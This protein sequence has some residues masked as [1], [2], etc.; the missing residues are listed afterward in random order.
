MR[1]L[2]ARPDLAYGNTRLRARR[3]RLLGPAQ[4]EALAGRDVDGLLAALA[5]DTA[6]A[7]DV[8]DALVRASGLRALLD[9][10]R[11]HLA[12]NLEE[13]RS[14][15]ADERARALVDLLLAPW[16]LHNL[17]VLLRGRALGRPAEEVLAEHVPVGAIDGPAA[18]AIAGQ[19]DLAH[20]V[21]LLYAWRL[22]DPETARAL[23]RAWPEWERTEDLPALERAVAVAHAAR[24]VAA[25]R[26]AGD[27]AEPLRRALRWEADARNVLV[28]LR[29]REALAEGELPE[30]PDLDALLLPGGRLRAARLQDAARRP[31]PERLAA[32]LGAGTDVPGLPEALG[33]WARGAGLVEVQGVL[34]QRRHRALVDGFT[35]GDPL[36]LDVPLAWTTAKAV[37]VRNLRLLATG[38]ARGADPELLRAELE[39]VA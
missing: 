6:Y 11:S 23:D 38:A 20:A 19:P 32:E 14:F 27:E 10:V 5:Q 7:P 1:L 26:A 13:L 33:R 31:E 17:L 37:E 35:R 8:Q 36:G 24:R 4:L 21:S 3:A 30:L 39:A 12:R 18:S 28:A 25:L 22:P 2:V 16:D 34:E 29:V 15:Y 9:A